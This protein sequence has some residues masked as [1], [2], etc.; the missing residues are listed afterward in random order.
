[1]EK[2]ERCRNLVA[3]REGHRGGNELLV[4]GKIVRAE[5]GCWPWDERRYFKTRAWERLEKI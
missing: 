2:D 4:P 3:G 1:M 5:F